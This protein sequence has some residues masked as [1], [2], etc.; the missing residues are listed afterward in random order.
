MRAVSKLLSKTCRQYSWHLRQTKRLDQGQ[1][2]GNQLHSKPPTEGYGKS[3][4]IIVDGQ[5]AP[6]AESHVSQSSRPESPLDRGSISPGEASPPECA[7]LGPRDADTGHLS[8]TNLPTISRD[9]VSEEHGATRIMPRDYAECEIAHMIAII[10][11]W[12]Q[13]VMHS[14]DDC[15]NL[16]AGAT[17]FHSL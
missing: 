13:E 5:V 3:P 15:A 8:E 17:R 11:D 2:P 12:V 4:S 16:N 1:I 6:L 9:P 14:N 10:S 7:F